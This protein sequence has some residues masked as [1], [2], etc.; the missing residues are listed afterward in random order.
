MEH[1]KGIGQRNGLSRRGKQRAIKQN[2]NSTPPPP[3][4][5]QS[6][7]PAKKGY[8][9]WDEMSNENETKMLSLQM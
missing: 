9:I 2:M 1:R 4:P 5:T 8:I 7:P 6:P 3:H